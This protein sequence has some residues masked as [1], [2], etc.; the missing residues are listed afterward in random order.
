MD[1]DRT[2]IFD[3]D[4]VILASNALKT[5]AFRATLE[6]DP[7]EQVD[8]FIAYHQAHNGISRLRKFEHY[9]RVLRAASAPDEEARRAAERYSAI[10]RSQLPSCN[11]IPGVRDFL[12]AIAPTHRTYVVSGGD[13]DEVQA[14]LSKKGIGR[15][16]EGIFGSPNTKNDVLSM[17]VEEGRLP[18]P[19]V[20]FG[21]SPIDRDVAAE[22]GCTFVLVFGES[23]WVDGPDVCRREGVLCVKDFRDPA[24]QSLL[25]ASAADREPKL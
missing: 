10:V 13:Q 21:D 23:E 12:A 14:V 11:E 9:Y 8:R 5:R 17:L 2:A 22:F 1:R 6:G 7:V 4:G 20:Y 3:C 18:E 19:R 16:F 15:H 24:L 25:A